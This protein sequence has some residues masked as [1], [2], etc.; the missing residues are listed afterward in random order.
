MG[1]GEVES[2]G[3]EET[4][5]CGS[6]KLGP[7]PDRGCGQ[8]DERVRNILARRNCIARATHPIAEAGRGE[9]GVESSSCSPA[10]RVGWGWR[11][12]PGTRMA[13]ITHVH[14]EE[15]PVWNWGRMFE[16]QETHKAYKPRSNGVP[17][18]C[19]QHQ[20]HNPSVAHLSPRDEKV[21]T[22]F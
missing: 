13:S 10:S 14:P 22:T 5:S 18:M 21:L 2:I 11:N 6:H 3:D 8:V 9:G 1:F 12:G 7:K 19:R 15:Y 17:W 4:R 20:Q 16:R